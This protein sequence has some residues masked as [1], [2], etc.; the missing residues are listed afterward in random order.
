MDLF[1]QRHPDAVVLETAQMDWDQN[2]SEFSCE[3][4]TVRFDAVGPLWM[5]SDERGVFVRSHRTGNILPFKLVH[6]QLDAERDV[7]FWLF[8]NDK[9]GCG[10]TIFN[11]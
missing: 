8:N 10:L 6:R 1:K 9:I 4:S 3:A 7:R 5:D 2:T 11:D